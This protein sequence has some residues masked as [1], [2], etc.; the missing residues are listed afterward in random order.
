VIPPG[1]VV[2]ADQQEREQQPLLGAAEVEHSSIA[3]HGERAQR[4]DLE[5]AGRIGSRHRIPHSR[6]VPAP[7]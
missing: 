4:P 3:L 2:G 1:D 5:L 7:S 6:A